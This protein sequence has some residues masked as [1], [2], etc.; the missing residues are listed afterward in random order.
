MVALH[1]QEALVE[2]ALTN[3]VH[4]LGHL[5]GGE[6]DQFGV[7]GV[8]VYPKHFEY[9]LFSHQ[10]TGKTSPTLTPSGMINKGPPLGDPRFD[11]LFIYV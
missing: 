5:E 8:T 11:G 9:M 10:N 6:E 4:A 2:D 7:S 1:A 3:N